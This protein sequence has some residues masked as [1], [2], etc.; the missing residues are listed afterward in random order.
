M[1]WADDAGEKAHRTF[2]PYQDTSMVFGLMSALGHEDVCIASAYVRF[3]PN[4]GHFA[5]HERMS[6][7]G[8]KRTLPQFI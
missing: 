8:T 4:S 7:Y 5:V 3:T 2:G 6:A 1:V